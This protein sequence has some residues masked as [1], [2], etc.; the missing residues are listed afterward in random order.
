[1]SEL[2]EPIQHL[3]EQ[4]RC[5][6]EAIQA[7]FAPILEAINRQQEV[8][9]GLAG[10]LIEAM[11]Q[12]GE[13]ESRVTPYLMDRGWHL[14]YRFPVTWFIHLDSL[15]QVGNH[16][17]VDRVM[18]ALARERLGQVESRTCERF[19]D[20]ANILG[21]AFEAHRGGK[22]TLS[23][24][25]LIAQSD[26]IGCEILGIPR[27]FFKAKNRS[28]A[29]Q[30]KLSAFT[31]FG[32]PY[33][34]GGTTQSMLGPLEKESSLAAAT[35]QRDERRRSEPWFG[36][37]NRHGVQHGLDLDYPTEENSLRCVTLLEYLLDVD[38]ILQQEIPN[39]VAKL[40]KLCKEGLSDD[41]PSSS[42]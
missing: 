19:P 25:A 4:V 7:G 1:M 14:T 23:I 9:R 18:C 8:I 38:Q 42:A 35:E 5:Q 32:R 15:V 37:L 30:A 36:P 6:Q 31:L 33:A 22:Y 24:P 16:D 39:E 2:S 40:N 3:L 11:K 27:Q 20:R 17:E 41:S 10:P 13:A 28:V 12:A 34:L 21:D 26:G 29:L